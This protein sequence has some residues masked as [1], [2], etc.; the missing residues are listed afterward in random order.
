M[1]FLG[2]DKGSRSRDSPF[3]D[4]PSHRDVTRHESPRLSGG[5]PTRQ[6]PSP[7]G[8]DEGEICDDD[9]NGG[10]SPISEGGFDDKHVSLSV[11]HH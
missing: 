9:D 6:P 7:A 10:M 5:P 1:C 11:L 3:R 2:S 4:S 8:S